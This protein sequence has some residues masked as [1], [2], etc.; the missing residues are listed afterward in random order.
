[1][2]N[3]DHDRPYDLWTKLNRPAS[4]AV[5]HSVSLAEEDHADVHAFF[6]AF[7]T[8]I[9]FECQKSFRRALELIPGYQTT[10]N[11]V[12]FPVLNNI[13]KS[14]GLPLVGTKDTTSAKTCEQLVGTL[15]PTGGMPSRTSL[16]FRTAITASIHRP[17]RIISNFQLDF[18]CF[19]N[20][21][22]RHHHH[23]RSPT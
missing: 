16:N 1:M 8:A 17:S 2:D 19:S 5:Q 11:I 18:S 22:G 6:H 23:G 7:P 13:A 9:E 3:L 15:F 20:A 12:V 21:V 14:G 4:S 10:K